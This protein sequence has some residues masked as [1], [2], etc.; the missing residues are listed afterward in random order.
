MA[1]ERPSWWR[2]RARCRIAPPAALRR[3]QPPAG[4]GTNRSQ[5]TALA[6]YLHSALR[7]AGAAASA[8]ERRGQQPTAAG[9]YRLYSPQ[10]RTLINIRFRLHIDIY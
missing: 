8:A 1:Q 5:V 6:F 7:T 9:V 4:S 3:E 10:A 2:P